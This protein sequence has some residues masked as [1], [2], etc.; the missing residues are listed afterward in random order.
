MLDY[1]LSDGTTRRC[2]VWLPESFDPQ[3]SWPLIV[4]LHAYEE[5][6]ADNEHLG[7][8]IGPAL[9]ARPELYRAVVLLPQCPA[10]RVWSSVDR[11][12]SAGCASAEEHIDASLEAAL[13]AYPIDPA[14]VALTGASMGGYGTFVHGARRGSR[15][16]R[17]APV[18]GGGR[19]E[20]AAALTDVPLWVVHGTAD[21]V[22]PIEESQR[23]VDAVRAAAPARDRLRFDAVE[24]AGHDVWDRAYVDADFVRF[25]HCEGEVSTTGRGE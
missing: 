8:G 7:V 6:G 14:R 24:G 18:C 12:W 10:D 13:E 4:F 15:Y 11:P 19:V 16:A 21:D 20:D 23:M 17:L 3:R 5:R 22:V 25:L 9:D 1:A 2:P